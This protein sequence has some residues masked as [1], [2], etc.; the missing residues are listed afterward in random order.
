MCVITTTL[1]KTWIYRNERVFKGVYTSNS[2]IIEDIMES[3]YIWIK[4]RAKVEDFSF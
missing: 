4:N 2:R 1:W 3:T